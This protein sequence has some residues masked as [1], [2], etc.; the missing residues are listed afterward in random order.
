MKGEKVWPFEVGKRCVKCRGTDLSR[1][2]K[3]VGQDNMEVIE[4][5]C[6]VCSG[7]YFSHTWQHDEEL[8]LKEIKD[9]N[10]S[11][12]ADKSEGESVSK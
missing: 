12:H 8:K 3:Y 7:E 4:I 10:Q 2:L 6:R 9:E 11:G 1:Q 5:K